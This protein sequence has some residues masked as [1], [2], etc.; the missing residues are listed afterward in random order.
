MLRIIQSNKIKKLFHHL[1]KFYQNQKNNQSIFVSFDVIVPSMVMGEWLKKQLADET[2][3][4]AMITTEFWGRYQLN[5]M[6]KVLDDYA[7]DNYKKNEKIHTV[8]SVAMLSKKV[9]QW[10][11]FGYCLENQQDILNYDDNPLYIF[12]ANIDVNSPDN[13]TT[14]DTDVQNFEQRLWQFAND[15]ASMLNRYMTYRP[16][17]LEIWQKNQHL[18]IENM[19]AD[20]DFLQN[21]LQG[22]MG[23]TMITT[24]DWLVEHYIALEKAQRLLWNTLFAKDYQNREMMHQQFWQALSIDKY[25]KKLPKQLILFT[26]QQLPPNELLDLQRFSQFTDVV[27]LHFNPSEQFWADIVDKHWLLQQQLDNPQAI[28]LR[29]YGHTLLSRFGKQS[30]EVFAMLASLSGNEFQHIEWQDTFVEN[31]QPQTLLSYLQQD[32][33]MLEEIQTQQ[34]IREMLAMDNQTA[35]H[36]YLEQIRQLQKTG[37]NNQQAFSKILQKLNHELANKQK[38]WQLPKLDTSLSIHACYSTVRQLEV[39]RTM[40]VSWLNYTDIDD[41]KR[42]N[43]QQL[44]YKEK[45]KLS[46]ILVLLPDIDAQQNSIEAIFPKGVGVDGY[47]LPAKVTGVVAKEVN[48]LWQALTGYYQLL[49]KAG[50]RFSRTE[51]FDWLMLP[52]IYESFNLSLDDMKRACDLLEQAGFIRGFDEQH[53]Q[54]TLH[55]SDDDYRFTFAFALERLV[56][57]LLMPNAKETNFGEYIN[58]LGE[59]ETIQPFDKVGMNDV[60][61][62]SVLCDI[63]QTLHDNRYLGQQMLSVA[64]WLEKIESFM[65][66]KFAVFEQTNNQ[67]SKAMRA[68]FSAQNSLSR[69][70]KASQNEQHLTIKLNFILESVAEQLKSQQVSA[71]PAGVI[72]FARIGAVRNI[73]YKLIVLLNMNFADFPQREPLNRY[74][75]MQASVA[76]RGDKFREDDDLGAFLDAILCAEESCWLFYNGKSHSDTNEHLPASPV[77]ELLHFLQTEVQLKTEQNSLSNLETTF[78]KQVENYLVTHHPALP[79]DKSYFQVAENKT[80]NNQIWQNIQTQKSHIYPPAQ[81]WYD[82]HTQLNNHNK[83]QPLIEKIQL[84]QPKQLQQWWQDWQQIKANLLSNMNHTEYDTKY[85]QLSV[86]I[87]A[88]QNPAESFI[89][90]QQLFMIADEQ[91]QQDLESLTLDSL[92]KY[93]LKSDILQH[94]FTDKQAQQPISSYYH[95]LPAGVG[96]YH[97]LDDINQQVLVNI[98]NLITKLQ[99]NNNVIKTLQHLKIEQL[100]TPCQEQTISINTATLDKQGEILSQMQRFVLTANLPATTD[101]LSPDYWISFLPNKYYLASQK[102]YQIKFLL[103]CWLLHLCWQVLLGKNREQIQMDKGFSVWQFADNQTL[104]LPPLS[105]QQAEIYLQDWLMLWQLS[106]KQVLV[107]PPNVVNEYLE[108][109]KKNPDN[110]PTTWITSWFNNYPPIYENSFYHKTWQILLHEQKANVILPFLS[111]FAHDIYQPMFDYQQII[112]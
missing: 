103:K 25:Q 101:V 67:N 30:R 95:L 102:K 37:F 80:E 88:M 64:D 33:L 27:L 72:T 99:K 87:R 43:Y 26:V 61:I 97:T 40:L 49:N 53:L 14:N 31:N 78:E 66:D 106:Q 91:E 46:D 6:K 75:L 56:A 59:I 70:V 111:T 13:V 28:Y 84:W 68:I 108:N 34:K 50:A 18:P 79:F 41:D 89:K 98:E 82:I 51:V 63:F 47:T 8:P 21:R 100:L 5:L 20:K 3:I 36:Q 107:L 23:D 112:E 24:P 16:T 4:S 10:K 55:Q 1:L 92:S 76:K 2:G 85:T 39:L 83:N 93:Q 11:I 44:P 110:K 29:D 45:R 90:N 52:P 105:K 48:Q 35:N 77:Q 81:I 9:M 65:K 15:M 57:G 38:T 96:R 54:Q 12:L 71:E 104:Y 22:R 32:I 74:N 94:C 73:P 69:S 62:I 109:R 60:T 17:W 19:I 42:Q 86:I 58:Q 7:R